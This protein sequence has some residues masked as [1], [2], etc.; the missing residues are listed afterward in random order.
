MAL[1]QVTIW[2]RQMHSNNLVAA[3]SI[4]ISSSTCAK[5]NRYLV[6]G[7]AVTNLSDKFGTHSTS[8]AERFHL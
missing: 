4:M 5:T 6:I 8:A 1:V 3:I 7:Q 2:P